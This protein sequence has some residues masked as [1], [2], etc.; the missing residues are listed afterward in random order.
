MKQKAMIW[1]KENLTWIY[2][3]IA[4]VCIF[5][6]N[7]IFAPDNLNTCKLIEKIGFVAL[8][9]G[10]FAGVL[11]SIQFTGLFREE[12]HKVISGTEFLNNRKD[13]PDLWK[14]IT[15]VIYSD[16]FPELSDV[17]ENLI[18][19][20]YLPTVKN[21]YNEDV[22][23]SIIVDDLSDDL[24]IEYTQT[25]EYFAVL[26]PENNNSSVAF[27]NNITDDPSVIEKN[28][29]ITFTIDGDEYKEN[30]NI[31]DDIEEGKKRFKIEVPISGKKRFKVS[32]TTKHKY[33]LKGENYKLLR[34][35][36]ITKNV[37]VTVSFDENKMQVSFFN[38]GLVNEFIPIHKNLKNQI[39]R[40]HRDDIILPRQG[41]GLTFNKK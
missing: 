5:W 23:V 38:I 36:T 30:G 32:F 19:S 6:A 2:F 37:D 25:I 9:S 31:I 7:S 40:R 41:F 12:L 29:L 26:D 39:S 33:S 24:T 16:K 4:I 14:K 21:H 10:V 15:K 13:L 20:N 17:I 22:V 1:V 3:V 35:N 8:T 18:L 28:E 11:K 27:S 34:F